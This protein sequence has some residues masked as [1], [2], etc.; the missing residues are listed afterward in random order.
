MDLNDVN[1]TINYLDKQTDKKLQKHPCIGDR[2]ALL[3][4]E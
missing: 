3:K 1:K 2:F 4:V